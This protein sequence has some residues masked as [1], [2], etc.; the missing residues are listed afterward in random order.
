M[1]STTNRRRRMS[2][3]MTVAMLT[4]VA[5]CGGS[6]PTA[7]SGGGGGSTSATLTAV[8]VGG[9]SSVTLGQTA[10]LKATAMRSDGSEQDVTSQAAWL[11]SDPAVAAVST[12]GVLTPLKTGNVT[13]T[14]TY[15]GKSGSSPVAVEA[16]QFSL[17]VTLDSF[18]VISTCDDFTQG[19]TEGEYSVKF[20]T[21]DAS[22][23]VTDLFSTASY[24]G[25]TSRP[26]VLSNGRAGAVSAVGVDKTYSVSGQAGQSVR[27]RFNATEWDSQIVLIPPSTRWI[28]DGDMDDRS[29]SRTHSYSNGTFTGLGANSLTLGSGNCRIQA[30]YTVTLN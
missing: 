7:P 27:V 10:Q 18:V 17:R 20:T 23:R 26:V 13:V 2:L 1:K 5:A 3:G 9:T 29:T 11:S 28:H 8:N 14:A 4:A 22:G 30:N 21:A 6:S 12:T 24:P 19:L 25:S 16:P 15:Q